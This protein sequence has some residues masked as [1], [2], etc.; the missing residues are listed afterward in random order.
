MSGAGNLERQTLA[1]LSEGSLECQDFILTDH[2]ESRRVTG[3]KELAEPGSGRR[4]LMCVGR[5]HREDGASGSF[6]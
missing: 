6:S 1:L 3:Q 2:G 5:T 4:I